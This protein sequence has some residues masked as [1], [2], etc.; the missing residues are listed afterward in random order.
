MDNINA[1]GLAHITNLNFVIGNYLDQL[2]IAKVIPLYKK[3]ESHF[4]R[5]Y[6]PI[7]LLSIHNQIIGK[8]VHKHLYQFLQKYEILYKF[9]FGFRKDHSTS[10]ANIEIVENIKE[11]IQNEK[12][13]WGA[14]LDLS[15]AFDTISHNILLHKLEHVGIKGILLELV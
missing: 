9:Q 14:Y 5:N 6:R 10:L 1:K 15:K 12:F 4:T 13:V 7:T 11:E 3:C 8:L 2:K